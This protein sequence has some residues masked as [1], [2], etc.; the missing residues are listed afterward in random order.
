MCANHPA[1]LSMAKT[2]SRAA[3]RVWPYGATFSVLFLQLHHTLQHIGM[4]LEMLQILLTH[5][6]EDI[7]PVK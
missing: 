3:T 6:P 4:P 1:N 7:L 2:F 5:K